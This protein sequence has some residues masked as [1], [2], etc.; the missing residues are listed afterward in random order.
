M[1]TSGISKFFP[2]NIMIGTIVE[3]NDDMSN[4]VKSA[5]I[6]P[7]IDFTKLE[8]VFIITNAISDDDYP[9]GES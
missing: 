4:F 1:V 6:K 7:S 5:T 3:V 9:A 8:E 2:K